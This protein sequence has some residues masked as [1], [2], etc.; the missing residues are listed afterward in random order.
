MATSD[1]DDKA[2]F[3]VL[4]KALRGESETPPEGHRTIKGWSELWGCG[5]KKAERAVA[6]AVETNLMDQKSYRVAT[7][8]GVI[9]PVTHCYRL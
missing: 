6:K 9:R 5:I 8:N 7:G 1:L 2:L 4:T 3:D